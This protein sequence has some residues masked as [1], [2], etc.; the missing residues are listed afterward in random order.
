MTEWFHAALMVLVIVFLTAMA[1][2]ATVVAMAA[3]AWMWEDVSRTI[4][5]IRKPLAKPDHEERDDD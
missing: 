1:V 5:R 4:A 3:S 2:V